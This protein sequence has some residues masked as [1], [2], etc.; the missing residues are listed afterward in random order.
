MPLELISGQSSNQLRTDEAR[1]CK[2]NF[3]DNADFLRNVIQ[4]YSW[5]RR[6][7][8]CE[9]RFIN[10]NVD[11]IIGVRT[12]QTVEEIINVPTIVPQERVMNRTAKQAYS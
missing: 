4:R 7:S 6:T 12:P 11:Q 1:I 8:K 3:D 9:E 5:R 10:M 2:A